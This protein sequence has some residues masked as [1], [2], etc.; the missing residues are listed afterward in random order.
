MLRRN[1]K[2]ACN[3]VRLIGSRLRGQRQPGSVCR[4]AQHRERRRD[5]LLLIIRAA[6]RT[7]QR[8]TKAMALFEYR[9]RRHQVYRQ[10]D[11]LSRRQLVFVG[12][13]I[14]MPG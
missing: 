1:S 8:Q 9:R 4:I 10:L 7:R 13:V 14:T 5:G 3:I 11:G 6:L 2:A 12:F